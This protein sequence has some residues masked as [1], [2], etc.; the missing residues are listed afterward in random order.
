MV[1]AHT[2]SHRRIDK[3]RNRNRRRLRRSDEQRLESVDRRIE[4]RFDSMVEAFDAQ[5]YAEIVM[6]ADAIAEAAEQGVELSER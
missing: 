3:A 4:R 1:G 5:D 6:Q 2:L